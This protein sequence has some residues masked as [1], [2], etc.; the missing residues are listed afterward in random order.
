MI[1][2]GMISSFYKDLKA[3][4]CKLSS[5]VPEQTAIRLITESIS[6]MNMPKINETNLYEIACTYD[7]RCKRSTNSFVHLEAFVFNVMSLILSIK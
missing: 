5:K 1:G 2:I 7:A 6:S 4:L 3:R